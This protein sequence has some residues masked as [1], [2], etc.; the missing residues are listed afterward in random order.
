[1][2]DSFQAVVQTGVEQFERQHFGRP[3]LGEDDGL[4]RLEACGLC[5]ADIETFRG[6]VAL[7]Y[8]V[9]PGHEPVSWLAVLGG[10]NEWARRVPHRP[11]IG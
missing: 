6:G 7:N 3:T 2:T 5:G 4:L 8:P 10:G 11:V 1:M 9:I